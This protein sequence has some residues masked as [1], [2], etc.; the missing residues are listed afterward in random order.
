MRTKSIVAFLVG[1]FLLFA[2]SLNA[3][4]R[5]WT[6]ANGRQ[7]KAEFVKCEGPVVTL[8]KPGGTEMTVRMR[9]L[10]DEDQEYV[11]G[12]TKPGNGDS[13]P[14]SEELPAIPKK[15]AEKTRRNNGDMAHKDKPSPPSE[16]PSSD[17]PKT[18]IVEAKGSGKDKD[19]ALKDAFR[20]AVRKVVGAYVEEETVVKN[21]QIIKEQ[22]LTY[23]GGFVKTHGI[24][25]EESK[26]GVFSVTIWALVEQDKVVKRLRTTSM[27]VKDVPGGNIWDEIQSKRWRDKEAVAM[28]RSVLKDFPANCMTTEVVGEPKTQGQGE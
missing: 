1:V 7:F 4:M 10:S 6:R 14:A 28:L 17:Q 20:A 24:K 9:N 8:K 25:S 22:V 11:R 13:K 19:E 18:M 21:D 5:K 2:S 27:T 12:D 16:E 3:E 23:S 26:D 15:P